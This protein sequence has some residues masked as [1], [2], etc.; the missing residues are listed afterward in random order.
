MADETTSQ[1]QNQ[2][3][4][5]QMPNQKPSNLGTIVSVIVIVLAIY[6]A[7]AGAQDWWPFHSAE[8]EGPAMSDTNS[9]SDRPEETTEI[10][11]DVTTSAQ[12]PA[13]G[14]VSE[15]ATPCDVPAEFVV[16]NKQEVRDEYE[17]RGFDL[18]TVGWLDALL[19]PQEGEVSGET[20]SPESPR[21]G[22]GE[23]LV[24]LGALTTT[25]GYFVYSKSRRK[26]TV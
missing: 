8:D 20:T 23:W 21:T 10:C 5:N 15:Y 6:V 18:S 13:T 25:F 4:Q 11:L 12:D 24:V 3:P 14:E 1:N 26:Q 17:S 19:T 22:A 16:T 2:Q 7:L 9:P